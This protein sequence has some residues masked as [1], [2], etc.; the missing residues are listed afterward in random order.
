MTI[1]INILSVILY[2]IIWYQIIRDFKV[3]K[4]FYIL[5][6]FLYGIILG[7]YYYFYNSVPLTLVP[8]SFILLTLINLSFIDCKYYE[9]SGQSYWFLI[10]PAL[11]T[12]LL[13]GPHFYENILGFVISFVFFWIIDKI[14]GIEK[15]GGA[16]V[17]ILM[18]LSLTMSFFDFFALVGISFAID[19]VL[20]IVK[21][22]FDKIRGKVGRTRIPM[23]VA[24]TLSWLLIS[25]FHI[26]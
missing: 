14:I 4:I 19:L 15:I 10:V 20:F 26:G 24:I 6:P 18:I 21:F 1:T 3:K 12:V 23:I 11:A 9:I 13:A 2:Q 16:D 5:S 7:I 17:K 22:P 25:F 8:F